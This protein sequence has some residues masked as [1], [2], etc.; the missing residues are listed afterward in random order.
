MRRR[1]WILAF[2][3]FVV[4]LAVVAV[5]LGTLLK[6]VPD[7]YTQAAINDPRQDDPYRASDVQ[8]RLVELKEI[9]FKEPEW[10]AIFTQDDLNAYFREDANTNN[11][12]EPRLNGLTAPRVLI[13]ADRIRF[14]ARYGSGFWSSVVS[15]EL[16]AWVIADEPNLFAVELVSLRGG[17][18]PISRRWM[19]DRITAVLS[20]KDFASVAWFRNSGNPVAVCRWMPNQTRPSTLLQ[21][22]TVADGRLEIGGRNLPNR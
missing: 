10:G 13:E 19:M 12:L 15:V 18:L 3:I 7:F 5:A 4:C 21:T 14:A 16:R 9:V 2:L 6:Q 17:S 22:L 8:T 11:L 20:A 1:S